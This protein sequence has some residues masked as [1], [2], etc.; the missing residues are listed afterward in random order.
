MIPSTRLAALIALVGT[1]VAAPASSAP[2]GLSAELERAGWQLLEVPG[3]AT[4]RF[5][6]SRPD[7]IDVRADDA[8]AFLYRPV[9]GGMGP[10][11]RLVWNWR[12]DEAVP[13]TDLSLASGDDRSLAVHVIFP[14]DEDRLSF[15]QRI[16]AGLTRL[17]AP[18][19]AGKVLT[20]VWGGAHP[21]GTVLA[22]PHLQ[23][24]GQII[25]LRSGAEPVGQWLMEDID[26][27]ADFRKAFGYRPPAPAFVAI[28]SDSDDTMSSTSGVIAGLAFED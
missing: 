4:A 11:R 12:V 19:L 2:A 15:W 5:T 14:L 10:K 1:L 23:R 21:Q 25:I 3:K 16:E 8:V 28:S 24:W 26:F 13:A 18:P 7:R 9:D 20:Y 17:A 22:N 6:Q 27:V